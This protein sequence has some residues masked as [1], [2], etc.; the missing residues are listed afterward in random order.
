[1]SQGLRSRAEE[2]VSDGLGPEPEREIRSTLARD[3][4]AERWT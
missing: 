2:L 3:M 4:G 1:M